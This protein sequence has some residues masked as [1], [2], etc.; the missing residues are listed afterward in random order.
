[1]PLKIYPDL[2]HPWKNF[3]ISLKELDIFEPS[4]LALE[5]KTGNTVDPYGKSIIPP[6]HQRIIIE[7]L[8]HQ[9]HTRL[10]EFRAF[11]TET[12]ADNITL[13]SDGF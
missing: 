3:T 10:K 5:K 13:Y 8:S 4:F 7:F 2:S 1:M 9:T 6:A 11:L 12:H